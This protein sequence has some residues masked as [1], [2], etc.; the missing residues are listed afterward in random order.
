LSPEDAP[1]TAAG[2]RGGNTV[3]VGEEINAETTTDCEGFSSRNL[4]ARAFKTSTRIL[5]LPVLTFETKTLRNSPGK[6]VP[7][8]ES[9]KTRKDQVI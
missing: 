7:V 3:R 9:G 2:A 6:A 8:L 4:A 5:V 1:G